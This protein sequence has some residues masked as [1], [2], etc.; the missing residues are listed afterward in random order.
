M[1]NLFPLGGT[2]SKRP[3]PGPSEPP[4]LIP[5]PWRWTAVLVHA[6]RQSLC[7]S[8]GL[9]TLVE[10]AMRGDIGGHLGDHCNSRAL[11][12]SRLLVLLKHWI[13]G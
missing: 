5:S 3:R 12:S 2:N 6:L 9:F 11:Q 7:P 13:L 4:A 10:M 8:P 1:S